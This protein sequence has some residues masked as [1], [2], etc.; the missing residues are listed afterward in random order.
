M[1]LNTTHLNKKVKKLIADLI[2]DEFSFIQKIKLRGVGSYRMIVEYASKDIK[3]NLN[4][5]EG[6]DYCSFE[7]RKKGV[8][9]HF[10]NHNYEKTSWLIP[11]YKLVIFKTEV[12]SVFDGSCT[13]KLKIDKN[14]KLNK[15]FIKKLLSLKE[16]Y[17]SQ[18]QTFD[19]A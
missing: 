13:V 6:I 1:L 2:G 9:L 15:K 17:S 10:H 3:K 8:M 5:N 16:A 12:L 7:L 19:L 11:F 18:Y 4:F 14:F